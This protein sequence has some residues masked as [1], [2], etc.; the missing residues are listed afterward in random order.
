MQQLPDGQRRIARERNSTTSRAQERVPHGQ[1]R[2]AR[3]GVHYRP[4]FSTLQTF[5]TD[6]EEPFD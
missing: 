4:D 3:E 5:F 2:I 1:R 6:L